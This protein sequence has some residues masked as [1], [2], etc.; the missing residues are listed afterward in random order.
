MAKITVKRW[1]FMAYLAGDNN[2]GGAGV[3]DLRETKK[4]GSTDDVNIIAQ[5]DHRGENFY[6]ALFR[7]VEMAVIPVGPVEL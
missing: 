6:R 3:A 4:V 1:T 2:P 7:T 5:F